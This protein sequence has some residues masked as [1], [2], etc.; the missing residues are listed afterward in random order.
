MRDTIT[1]GSIAGLAGTLPIMAV[2]LIFHLFG[3]K[4][5][6]AWEA[7]ADIF[8][9]PHLIHTPVG[10]VVGFAGQSIIGASGGIVMAYFLRLTGKDYYL[11]KGL[12]LGGLLWLS[13]VGLIMPMLHITMYIQNEPATQYM[14]ILNLSL[15]GLTSSAIVAKYGEF[16]P[17]FSNKPE[18]KVVVVKIEHR[19]SSIW[20]HIKD[21]FAR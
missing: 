20:Q 21:R 2:N 12:G 18:P 4:A 13:S 10:Y 15:F 7:S 11:L 1:I 3:F 16:K 8:L 9:S 19:K 17:F 5:T 14:I 6:P